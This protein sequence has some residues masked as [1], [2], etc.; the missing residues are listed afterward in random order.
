MWCKR[1]ER[2]QE[3]LRYKDAQEACDERADVGRGACLV[4]SVDARRS[5]MS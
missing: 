1:R 3:R 2:R 5:L 4:R